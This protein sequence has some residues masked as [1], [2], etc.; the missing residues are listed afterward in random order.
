M[1]NTALPRVLEKMLVQEGSTN[2]PLFGRVHECKEIWTL[3]WKESV[4]SEWKES[5]NSEWN[6]VNSA[7]EKERPLKV[8][9]WNTNSLEQTKEQEF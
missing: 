5:V 2:M 8:H 4:N 1:K 3:E 6:E 7:E 9:K